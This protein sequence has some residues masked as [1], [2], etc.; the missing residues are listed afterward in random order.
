[1]SG[2]ARG[3]AGTPRSRPC[4]A[5][6]CRAG[7]GRCRLG[8]SSRSASSPE[9]AVSTRSRAGRG[10]VEQPDVLRLVVD[11]Q[12]RDCRSAA[13]VMPAPQLEEVA[14]PAAGRAAHADRLLDVAVEPGSKAPLPVVVHGERGDRDDRDVRRVV[15]LARSSRSASVPSMPGS[16]RS[17]R[18]RSGGHR[19]REPDTV[20][21][22]RRLDHLVA[23]D[24][25]STSRTSLRFFALSSTTRI[26]VGRSCAADPDVDRIWAARRTSSTSTAGSNPPF[27]ATIGDLAAQP[28]SVLPVSHRLGGEDDDRRR[29]GRRRSAQAPPGRRIRPRLAS[30][31]PG[32]RPRVAAS[33]R[34]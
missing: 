1:M 4:P 16:C 9:R 28:L 27:S 19:S 12:D 23:G 13:S 25:R 15:A 6:R 30:A 20:L 21:P 22:G 3:S 26:R 5:S 11:D 24:A 10:R 29:P 8:S 7:R 32:P 34:S 33:V 14:G 31:S 17:I 2:V 18:T